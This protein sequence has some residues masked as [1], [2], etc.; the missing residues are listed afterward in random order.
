MVERRLHKEKLKI[1]FPTILSDVDSLANQYILPKICSKYGPMLIFQKMTHSVQY[2]LRYQTIFKDECWINYCFF[3]LHWLQIYNL[4]HSNELS[5]VG[6]Q[7][8]GATKIIKKKSD[9]HHKQSLKKHDKKSFEKTCDLYTW[10]KLKLS[11]P[12]LTFVT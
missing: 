7:L 5:T 11:K 10:R 9:Q 4:H 1:F 8:F 12:F 6:F 2:S 3:F